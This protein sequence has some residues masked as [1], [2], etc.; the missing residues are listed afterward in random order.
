M[1]TARCLEDRQGV[2][3]VHQSKE[4]KRYLGEIDGLFPNVVDFLIFVS[5]WH[6]RRNKDKVGPPIWIVCQ[7]L[8][9]QER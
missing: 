9:V 1:E 4:P 6:Q 2:M 3:V 5:K 8:Y 7:A